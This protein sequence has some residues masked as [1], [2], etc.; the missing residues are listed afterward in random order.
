[1]TAFDS[2]S[3]DLKDPFFSREA[4]ERRRDVLLILVSIFIGTGLIAIIPQARMA[5]VL[6][7][8]SGVLL[9]AYIALLVR[10]QARATERAVKLRYMPAQP[11]LPARRAPAFEDRR[12]IAR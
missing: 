2:P 12:V 6:T 4:R 9:V 1:M 10:T 11:Q 8:L 3:R 7:G 5:L